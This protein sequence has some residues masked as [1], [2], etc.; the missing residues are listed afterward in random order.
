[1]GLFL[2]RIKDGTHVIAENQKAAASSVHA[3]VFKSRLFTL[4]STLQFAE[5]VA[6][7]LTSFFSQF[8]CS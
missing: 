7:H 6:F 5:F 2:C 1:M 4:H 3:F 8:R